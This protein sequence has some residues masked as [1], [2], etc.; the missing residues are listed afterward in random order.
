MTVCTSTGSGN[1]FSNRS[2]SR[3]KE[4]P[5]PRAP[6]TTSSLTSTV[7]SAAASH[8]RDAR[9]TLRPKRSP[10]CSTGSPMATPARI[11]SGVSGCCAL[12]RSRSRPICTAEST[13]SAGLVNHAPIPSPV[14]LNSD[15]AVLSQAGP[16]GVVVLL[17]EV[18]PRGVA[19]AHV[20]R[21]RAHEVGEQDDAAGGAGGGQVEAT[22]PASLG[23]EG[24][25][26]H[27]VERQARRAGH[28]G[29]VAAPGGQPLG[30]LRLQQPE[31]GQLD[32]PR[33]R[34]RLLHGH[35]DPLR[36]PR[37]CRRWP[38]GSRRSAG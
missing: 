37:P 30:Q 28:L 5:G 17:D 6:S 22:E 3:R 25:R 15:P 38:D 12:A 13:A 2:P 7:P 10:P 18:H 21:R 26:A 36:M 8:S 9:T 20:E 24:Q 16:D 31:P 32:D 11:M 29:H 27:V 35:V 34:R 14:C 1:P 23:G 19:G 4:R 33:A